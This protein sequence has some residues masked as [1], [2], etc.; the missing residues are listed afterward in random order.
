MSGQD[1]ALCTII[2][3]VI[4]SAFLFAGDPDVKDALIHHLMK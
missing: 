1:K 4:L 2:F 3:L